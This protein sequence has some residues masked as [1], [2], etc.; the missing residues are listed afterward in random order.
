MI[1]NYLLLAIKILNRRK[2]YTFVSLFGIAITLMVLIL[3][4][5]VIESFVRPGGPERN[6][7]RVLLASMMVLSQELPNGRGNESMGS[8]GYRFIE[9]NLLEMQ[10]PELISVF[11]ESIG[12]L[13]GF[14][15]GHA[16]GFKDGVEIA[17]ALKRSDANYWKILQFDFIEGRP[18]NEEEHRRGA[19]VAVISESTRE[20]Y[21]P[22]ESA[23]GKTVVL[24]G[25]AYEVVG[26]VRDVPGLQI[27]AWSDIWIPLFA[28]PST[29]FRYEDR[30]NLAV[31]ML[32]RAQ[33]EMPAMK[34][35]YQRIMDNY[36]P[37][38]PR[39]WPPGP[40]KA[41]S[42]LMTKAE[43]SARMIDRR[44]GNREAFKEAE[45]A[46]GRKVLSILG[47]AMLIFMLL[48]VINFVNIN[49]SRILERTSEIG[50]RKSFGA[51]SAHLVR[52]FIVE[53]LVVTAIG[54][55][56]G[57]LLAQG[58]LFLLTWSGAFADESFRMDY[59]VFA[60]GLLYILVFAL[61]SAAYP[62]WKMSRLDPVRALKGA[63]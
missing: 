53:N 35:E 27:L 32:A 10:T 50:V 31:M 51:S 18:F 11:T 36:R 17:S 63:V 25:S 21:F 7:E 38:L 16:V 41:Y 29:E 1:R 20:R 28:L 4:T 58:A 52:Q 12:V 45:S 22:G 48:P 56:L 8:L 24:D 30:G 5:S 14:D 37:A 44:T 39:G 42:Y 3:V 43:S 55:L 59:R 60:L 49:I 15:R 13:L 9:N 34:A 61:L 54:G 40:V 2:F 46:A 23:A 19:Y 26:V 57:F 33:E 62:A 47:I 6:S